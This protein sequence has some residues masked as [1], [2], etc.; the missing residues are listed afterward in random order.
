[1][2]YVARMEDNAAL[3]TRFY[4]AFSKRDHAT[5]AACYAEDAT[6]SDPVFPALQGA[7]IGGMWRMLCERGGDLELTFSGVRGTADGGGAHWEATYTFSATGRKVHNVIDATMT[8][9]DGKIVDHVD[10]F[11]FYRWSKMALGMPGLILGWTPIVR[12]KV[13]GQA[14]AQLDKFCAKSGI[15]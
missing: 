7:R 14:G 5:M 3:I 6:F 13:R 4:E 11:D 10:V 12:N 9:K 8:I 15:A 2:G 1:M